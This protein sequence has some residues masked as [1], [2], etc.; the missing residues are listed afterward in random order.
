[1]QV[2]RELSM[3]LQ[4]V[5]CSNRNSLQNRTEIKEVIVVC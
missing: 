5:Q 3:P 1:M 2:I 4:E